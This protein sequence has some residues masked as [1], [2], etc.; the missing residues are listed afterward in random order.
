[1]KAGRGR[2]DGPQ[3]VVP[4]HRA[5]SER[6]IAG[7]GW[8]S[9]HVGERLGWLHPSTRASALLLRRPVGSRWCRFCKG[10]RGEKK[11]ESFR[12]GIGCGLMRIC[13]LGASSCVPSCSLMPFC[14]TQPHSRVRQWR[15]N[16]TFNQHHHQSPTPVL[17][18]EREIFKPAVCQI[19]C[20]LHQPFRGIILR[21]SPTAVSSE[22][23]W[24]ISRG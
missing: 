8:V 23:S 4:I 7:L 21:F 6:D 13:V 19:P 18:K 9:C 11:R 3:W 15:H 5:G 20:F 17:E 14:C 10:D 12:C 16:R 1:M 22:E 2:S 24:R